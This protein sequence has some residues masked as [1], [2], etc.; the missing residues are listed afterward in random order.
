MIYDPYQN[1][2][3]I[4]DLPGITSLSTPDYTE[5]HLDG[6]DY[7]SSTGDIYIAAGAATAFTSTASGNYLNANFTGPNRILRYDPRQKQVTAEFDLS[8]AQRDYQE[9]TGNLTNG[10]QDM[11]EDCEGNSYVI[12][13]FGNS[14][15]KIEAGTG[16]V[17][18]WY[19]PPTYDKTYGFGG[20]FYQ[21]E[22]LVVSDTV[23]GGLVT[24]D[25][26]AE[27]AEPTY[28]ALSGLPSDYRP[29]MADGLYAPRKYGGRIALWSDDF[30]GTSV[31]GSN[32]GWTTATYLGLVLNDDPAAKGSFATATFEI[33]ARIFASV[34][35]FQ[36][37]L[38]VQPKKSFP[39]LDI[40]D[41]IEK[42]VSESG[43]AIR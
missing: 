29:L 23:S 40:T 24:F 12:G 5:Y 1:T 6:I 28:V 43:F 21:D 4:V 16:D 10:F 11:A 32:D 7:D 36:F 39:I 9:I 33:G 13:T 37:Q 27:M 34:E 19:T 26:T 15:V 18:L 14:I 38:P 22:K 2:T 35:F 3:E 25:T 31:Y 42:I 30:N 41:E 8:E 20:V 17:N